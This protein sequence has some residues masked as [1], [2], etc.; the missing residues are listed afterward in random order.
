MGTLD[1]MAP[2]QIQ[3]HRVDRGVGVHALGCLI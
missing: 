1:Y 2:E 3:G